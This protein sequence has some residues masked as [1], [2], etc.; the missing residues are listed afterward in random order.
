M[1]RLRSVAEN[2]HVQNESAAEA[3]E[4]AGAI[5]HFDIGKMS[6]SD[7][8]NSILL[9]RNLSGG[10]LTRTILTDAARDHACL[11]LWASVCTQEKKVDAKKQ[12]GIDF[13]QHFSSHHKLAWLRVKLFTIVS[14]N[15]SSYAKMKVTFNG[16]TSL[17]LATAG[18][19]ELTDDLR[20][21][22]A[23]LALEPAAIRLLL[24][25]FGSRDSLEKHDNKELSNPALWGQ[26]TTTFVNSR[27]WQPF[28]SAVA[29]H[30]SCNA[31]DPSSAP[32][33][34]GLDWNTV[35]EVFL[36]IRSDWTRLKTRVFGPT[37]CNSTGAALMKA[38]WENFINGSYLKFK[39]K[40]TAMYVFM[41]WHA[42]SLTG[43][44]PELCNRTLQ[45][46]QQLVLGVTPFKTPVKQVSSG[47]S[48]S[49]TRKIAA[50]PTDPLQTI[51]VAL[52]SLTAY[53]ASSVRSSSPKITEDQDLTHNSDTLERNAGSKRQIVLEEPEFDLKNFLTENKLMKWWPAIYDKLGVTSIRD[54]RFLGKEE[55]L[56][57]LASLPSFPR[58]KIVGLVEGEDA[59][60]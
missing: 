27:H 14:T 43:R 23:H 37:G 6:A 7:I 9:K 8:W 22:I 18:A 60:T 35:Q 47:S 15:R 36:D 34:P 57:S 46:S 16:H 4:L 33:S 26:L 49:S 56:R 32:P 48:S 55:I 44:L 29:E 42:A 52:Q 30:C 38:V 1:H 59:G 28:S 51:A 10:L 25:I 17:S 54:V 20:C 45:S 13:I 50:S 2:A 41:S 12:Q 39:N 53:Q 21:R 19:P 31:V 40:V 11:P 5:E 58:L 24:I 3:M